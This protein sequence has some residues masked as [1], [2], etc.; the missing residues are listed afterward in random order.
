MTSTMSD[1]SLRSATLIGR[2]VA[3]AGAMGALL[4]VLAL[5]QFRIPYK[6]GFGVIIVT[7]LLGLAGSAWWVGGIAGR[8]I[9]RRGRI[10]VAWGPVA[11]LACLGLT[12]LS[13]AL[14][15]GALYVEKELPFGLGQAVW[16]YFGK[17]LVYLMLSGGIP[18]AF[19][20][21]CCA[22]AIHCILARQKKAPVESAT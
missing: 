17:P 5:F 7:T 8:V 19:I 12:A 20:G 6:P 2:A 13:L 9:A 22:T 18:A 10:A 3:A 15:S 11:G 4:L 14:A 16:D 1:D 21:L